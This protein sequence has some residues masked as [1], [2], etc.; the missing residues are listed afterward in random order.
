MSL[1]LKWNFSRQAKVL[2]TLFA[3]TFAISL[4][5]S[6][7][8]RITTS[9]PYSNSYAE[10]QY[11]KMRAYLLPE[12]DERQYPPLLDTII[13]K[14]KA[15]ITPLLD[16]VLSQMSPKVL[17]ETN[18]SREDVDHFKRNF[19][20]FVNIDTQNVF[21]SAL[22]RDGESA[23]ALMKAQVQEF[24]NRLFLELRQRFE[25]QKKVFLLRVDYNKV[26]YHELL[27]NLKASGCPDKGRCLELKVFLNE[28]KR[29]HKEVP[30]INLADRSLFMKNLKENRIKIESIKLSPAKALLL[31]L[32]M[33]LLLS[34]YIEFFKITLESSK[35]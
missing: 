28:L 8:N 13:P 35:E 18:I 34:A 9:V 5:I 26:F 4:T 16:N 1:K 3:F 10:L 21:F 29:I 22:A 2:L 25:E 12:I 20:F 7:Q 11:Q 33:S 31:C 30:A 19:N 14:H 17:E 15:H 32:L 24:K 6:E 23:E 27:E